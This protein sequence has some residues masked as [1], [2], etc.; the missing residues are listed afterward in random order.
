MRVGNTKHDRWQITNRIVTMKV[1][2]IIG[3]ASIMVIAV[4]ATVVTPIRVSG[5]YKK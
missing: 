4:T 2:I 5:A 1:R 3:P